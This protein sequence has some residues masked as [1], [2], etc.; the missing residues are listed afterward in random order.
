MK[1]LILVLFTFTSVANYIY[2]SDNSFKICNL[3]NPKHVEVFISKGLWNGEKI[4]QNHCDSIKV[5]I[6]A[7]FVGF[8]V[9]NPQTL[10]H[11]TQWLE[12]NENY[13]YSLT[14]LKASNAGY[15]CYLTYIP[16]VNVT[17]EFIRYDPATGNISER[18]IMNTNTCPGRRYL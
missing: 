1:K 12:L 10:G 17:F 15:Y 5:D 18:S 16:Q 7:F 13:S 9:N 8:G 4:A 14:F 11:I 3:L 6:T 2:A